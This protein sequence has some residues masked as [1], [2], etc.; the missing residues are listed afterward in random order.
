MDFQTKLKI[1]QHE[2]VHGKGKTVYDLAEH[3]CKSYSYLCRISSL[4]EDLPFPS[5]LEVPAMKFKKNFDVLQ[6]KAWECG[7]ALIK[8]PGRVKMDKSEKNKMVAD[9]QK[10]SNEAISALLDVL[11][12]MTIASYHRFDKAFHNVVEKS[13]SVK[14]TIDKEANKQLELF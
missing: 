13:L 5:E 2:L 12:E 4:S 10:T 8:L 6:L 3:L 9:Y 7:F 11:E 14:K 1:K